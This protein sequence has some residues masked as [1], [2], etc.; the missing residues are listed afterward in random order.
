MAKS[1]IAV[2]GIDLGKNSCSLVGFDAAGAVVLRRRARRETIVALTAKLPPC[3]VAMEACCGAHHLGQLL[4]TQGHTIRLMSPEYVRP[5]VKAQKNDDRDA[6]AIAEAATR[7][8]MRFVPSRRRTS[9]TCRAC[10]G[11][12]RGWSACALC[13]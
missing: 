6:E 12:G 8:T 2:L 1:S 5:Y 13:S 7:P 10:T 9:S 3:V 11:S 4:A